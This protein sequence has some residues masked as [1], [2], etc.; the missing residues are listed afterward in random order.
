MDSPPRSF[1]GNLVPRTWDGSNEACIYVGNGQ[2]GPSGEKAL[3]GS[4]I[5]GSYTD[6][7]TDSLFDTTFEY[8]R[9]EGTCAA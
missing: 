9:L 4:V 1:L 7:I 5:E 3:L 2:G 8:D 6:Y